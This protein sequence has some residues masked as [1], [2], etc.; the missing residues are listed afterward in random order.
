METN[1]PPTDIT[2]IET[3]LYERGITLTADEHRAHRVLVGLGKRFL[4]DFGYGN[5]VERAH[6]AFAEAETI[7]W[8]M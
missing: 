7:A 8:R 2:K 4:I 3:H 5:L 6:L 1:A